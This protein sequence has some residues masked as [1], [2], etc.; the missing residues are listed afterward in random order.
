MKK[1]LLFSG[2][3]ASGKSTYGRW[4]EQHRDC[5]H[6]DFENE[7]LEQAGKRSNVYIG[8]DRDLGSL[9]EAVDKIQRTVIIDWGFPPDN[10]LSAVRRLKEDGVELWWF[11]G[12]RDAAEV[13]F[14]ERGG[15]SAQ[16]LKV[17]MQKIDNFWVE[18]ETLFSGHV[19]RSVMQGP[20]Y[21]PPEDVDK[22]IFS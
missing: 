2:I 7:T 21:L 20:K 1:L 6:W 8:T 17:Q 3:P 12:D 4:F 5:I 9:I 15:I 22:V 11:D 14:L 19:I 16:D 18:I 10:S 13:S